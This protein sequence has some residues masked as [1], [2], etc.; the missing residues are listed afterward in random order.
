M[1]KYFWEWKHNFALVRVYPW[2]YQPDNVVQG[3]GNHSVQSSFQQILTRYNKILAMKVW[4]KKCVF[5]EHH[6]CIGAIFFRRMSDIIEVI[7]DHNTFVFNQS[8][9]E[10]LQNRLLTDLKT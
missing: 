7:S 3:I 2:E 10:H 1:K 4:S 9:V 6:N 8:V 5:G